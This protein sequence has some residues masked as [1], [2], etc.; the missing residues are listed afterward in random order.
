METKGKPVTEFKDEYWVVDLV[1]VVDI[2]EHLNDLNL[3]RQRK[4]QFIY[5][6]FQ[7]ITARRVKILAQSNKSERFDTFQYFRCT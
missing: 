6:I 4:N 2:T 3:R 1:F 5:N 7:T